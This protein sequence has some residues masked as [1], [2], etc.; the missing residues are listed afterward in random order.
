MIPKCIIT[1]SAWTRVKTYQHD[2][3]L[4]TRLLPLQQ[5]PVFFILITLSFT[6]INVFL[7]FFQYSIIG[8]RYSSYTFQH[9]SQIHK[10]EYRNAN[11]QPGA[12]VDVLHKGL[13]YMDIETHLDEVHLPFGIACTTPRS[14]PV[15]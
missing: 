15:Y 4:S 1:I 9:E 13:Q 8:F 12:L 6:D 11:I 2:H 7:R 3:A 14:M 10:S 5:I